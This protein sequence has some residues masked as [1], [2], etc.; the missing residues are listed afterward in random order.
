VATRPVAF[1]HNLPLTYREANAFSNIEAG[2][3]AMGDRE[4]MAAWLVKMTLLHGSWIADELPIL[5]DAQR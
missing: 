4:V 2:F 5:H 1:I 3:P